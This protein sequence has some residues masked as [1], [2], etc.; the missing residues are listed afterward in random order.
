V[1]KF[2]EKYKAGELN[3]DPSQVVMTPLH[4]DKFLAFPHQA[5]K[6]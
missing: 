2:Y 4:V 3:V 1:G 6:S 5:S